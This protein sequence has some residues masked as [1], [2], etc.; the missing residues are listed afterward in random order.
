MKDFFE[1]KLE[2]KTIDE[3]ERI[4]LELLKYVPFIKD[5]SINIQRYLSVLSP[6]IG[7]KIQYDDPKTMEETIRRKK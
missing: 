3:Y 7:D 6:P 5:E 4:F 2:N 1:L